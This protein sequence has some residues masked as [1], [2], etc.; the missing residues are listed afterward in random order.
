M[1]KVETLLLQYLTLTVPSVVGIKTR[2]FA[3]M[4]YDRGG[5][6]AARGPNV[7]RH[8]VFSGPQRHSG[9]MFKSEITSNLSQ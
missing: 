2:S 4:S 8:S 7:A 5:Q 3:Q 6:I 1:L 9:N